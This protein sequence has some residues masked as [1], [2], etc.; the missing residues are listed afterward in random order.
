MTL[1][2]PELLRKNGAFGV[3]LRAGAPSIHMIRVDIDTQISPMVGDE[4]QSQDLVEYL[5]GES[6]EKL[7]QSNIF[8]KSV[9][10]MIQEGL[11]S[12]LVRTPE[13]VREKFRGSL[14][15]IVNE[16]ASGLICLIL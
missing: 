9:Y 5:S 10:A 11:T 6:P 2:K 1:E 4:K 13:D 3:K 15:K 14:T 16:G 12:K 7:W 8:G